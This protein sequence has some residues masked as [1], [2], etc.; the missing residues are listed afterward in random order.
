MHARARVCLSLCARERESQRRRTSPAREGTHSSPKLL[1][2]GAGESGK[3][4]FFKQMKVLYRPNGGIKQKP[5]SAFDE[6]TDNEAGP[7]AERARSPP[8]GTQVFEKIDETGE[9]D[10]QEDE[11]AADAFNIEGEGS[12]K[13]SPQCD[14]AVGRGSEK[15]SGNSAGGS[16]KTRGTGEEPSLYYA[17]SGTDTEKEGR[18]C[19][20]WRCCRRA[21]L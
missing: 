3:S 16:S 11:G 14:T 21:C 1:L 4:T 5:A 17:P 10:E 12:E 20:G 9:E 19:I 7:G 2:L 18:A 8:G 13:P 6:T 15:G